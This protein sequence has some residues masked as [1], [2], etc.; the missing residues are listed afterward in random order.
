MDETFTTSYETIAEQL[1]AQKDFKIGVI[2]S[3]NLNHATPAAY[4]AHQASRGNYYEIGLELIDSGFDYFAGGGLLQPDGKEGDQLNLYDLAET[5]GYT[6]AMTQEE[7]KAVKNGGQAILIAETLADSDA[8]SYEN[9]RAQDEWA[10][11]DYV[12]KASRSWTTTP[13]SS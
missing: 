9:D 3:V 12:K 11:A 5:A 4:Y 13:A 7:A 1:K 6:V 10:L 8:F 2:S